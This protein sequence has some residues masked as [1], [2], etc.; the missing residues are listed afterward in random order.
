M[1]RYMVNYFSL[2]LFLFFFIFTTH[3]NAA[4]PDIGDN[5]ILVCEEVED[6]QGCYGEIYW[7]ER[8]QYIKLRRARTLLTRLRT[9]YRIQRRQARA[10][11]DESSAENLT[12]LILNVRQSLSDVR[13]CWFYED[14]SCDQG[15][16]GGGGGGG[17]A[18]EACQ[19][20]ADPAS[21]RNRSYV[22]PRIVNGAVC[23]SA[24]QSPA[25]AIR[26]FGGAYCTG[27]L[28]TPDVVI[29]AAHCLEDADC[30]QMTVHA[31]GGGSSRSVDNCI[32]HPD[33]VGTGD[34]TNNDVAILFLSGN[35]SGV[36]LV[37][38]YQNNDFEVGENVVMAGYGRNEDNDENLRAVFNVISSFSTERISTEYIQGENGKGTT[39]NGDSG[40]PL[41]VLRNNEWQLVGTTSNGSA[42]DCALPGAEDSDTSNW[43]NLTSAS[44]I[45]FIA[46]NTDGVVD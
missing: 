15:G 33:W 40:G 31:A 26:Y 22:S 25:V 4:A 34:I 41:Y 30:S 46:Q 38:V 7:T 21:S 36:N 39:C 28:V 17:N 16:G 29:T 43:A 9:K 1:L 19:I 5:S 6:D 20:T 13:D 32:A 45:N 2:S 37:K 23:S 42:T 44:N 11:G 18:T 27:S 14:D 35:L 3:V 12:A 10:I 8:D 24:D